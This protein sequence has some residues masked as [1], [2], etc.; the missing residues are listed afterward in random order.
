MLKVLLK[1]LHK[2]GHL[3]FTSHWIAKE[4]DYSI[5][6]AT[7]GAINELVASAKCE[8]LLDLLRNMDSTRQQYK[9]NL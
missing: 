5:E 4:E 6:K 2:E 1:H 3:D 9:Y 7:E 8:E